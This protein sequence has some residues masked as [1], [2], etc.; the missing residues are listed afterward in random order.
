M[1]K[2]PRH[3]QSH[4]LNPQPL[5]TLAGSWLC[6][7]TCAVQRAYTYMAR[8]IKL[9][10]CVGGVSNVNIDVLARGM[11]VCMYGMYVLL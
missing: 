1:P 6:F 9:G 7:E 8:E 3:F 10:G 11:Y 5:F 4:F 2:T